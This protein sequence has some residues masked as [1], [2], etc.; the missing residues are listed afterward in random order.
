MLERDETSHQEAGHVE[1]VAG[2]VHE[3]SAAV[4]EVCHRR[5][6]RVAAGDVDGSHVAN[7]ASVNLSGHFKIRMAK[8]RVVLVLESKYCFAM[9]QGR[10]SIIPG[11]IDIAAPDE[12]MMILR[13][14]M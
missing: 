3:D 2:H 10:D 14:Q 6:S 8:S 5:R 11:N 4:L 12:E 13:G 9:Q 1:V 7:G